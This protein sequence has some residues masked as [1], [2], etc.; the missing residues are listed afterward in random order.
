M[1]VD[2][3]ETHQIVQVSYYTATPVCRSASVRRHEG[4]H[5]YVFSKAISCYEPFNTTA[6]YIPHPP[7]DLP[8]ERGG[9]GKTPMKVGKT[10]KISPMQGKNPIK[11]PPLQGEG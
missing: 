1:P 4:L 5:Y 11:F 2:K 7:P 8:L 9:I 3:V 6:T 10:N